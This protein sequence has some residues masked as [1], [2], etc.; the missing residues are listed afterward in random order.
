MHIREIM[1]QPAVTC[2]VDTTADVPA[3]LMWERDCGVIPLVDH[4]G[5][6][7]GIVTDRDLCMAALTQDK[8]LREIQVSSAM[9]R[10]VASCSPE[11]TVESAEAV[12]R[13]NQVRRVPVVD[14][15]G[16]PVGVLS[17]NDL[18]RLAAR[19]R[20]NGVDRE[21]VQT[22]AVVSEPRAKGVQSRPEAALRASA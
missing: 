16:L 19:G 6:L 5:R 7:A 18:A 3:H 10:G 20:K 15:E 22:L 2:P 8:P 21:F 9:A 4:D 1:S 14:E 11:D 17:M 13:A 12:M